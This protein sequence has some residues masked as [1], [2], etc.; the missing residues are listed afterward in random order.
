MT[1]HLAYG[2]DVRPVGELQRGICVTEA[3]KGDAS[4][5][6][7]WHGRFFTIYAVL[8]IKYASDTLPQARQ[9]HYVPQVGN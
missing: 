5:F 3:V 2:V 9:T 7:V 4:V 1:E 8:L 6:P